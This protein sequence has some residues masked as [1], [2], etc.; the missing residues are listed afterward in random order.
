MHTII[1]V[2]LVITRCLEILSVVLRILWVYCLAVLFRMKTLTVN[3]SH[4][5]RICSSQLFMCLAKILH[6][7]IRSSENPLKPVTLEILACCRGTNPRSPMGPAKIP[8]RSVE[9]GRITQRADL[10]KSTRGILPRF[11]PHGCVKP[12]T[13]LL[14]IMSVLGLGLRSATVHSGYK[15][16]WP[17]YV[18]S[19]IPFTVALG[20]PFILKRGHQQWLQ[21]GKIRWNVS[22]V[23]PSSLW[24]FIA[25]TTDGIGQRH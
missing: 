1:P 7:A 8:L 3:S 9:G 11:G 21:W 10:A 4:L 20:P 6:I 25:P 5:S 23:E 12:Y 24:W 22:T 15:Q 2:A 18:V 17:E 14:C 13:C 16:Y 19:L